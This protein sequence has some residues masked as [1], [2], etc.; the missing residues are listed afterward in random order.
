MSTISDLSP[1]AE[2]RFDN[3]INL[4]NTARNSIVSYNAV[5]KVFRTRF[6]ER[7]SHAKLD[8]LA[9]STTKHPHLTA[10]RAQ[11]EK[12]LTKSGSSFFESVSYHARALPALNLFGAHAS[13]LNFYSFDFPFLLAMKSDSARYL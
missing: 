2:L 8:T 6:D 7:R 10:G 13:S 12:L 5:Q 4:R 3:Y 1:S 9:R 11:Y